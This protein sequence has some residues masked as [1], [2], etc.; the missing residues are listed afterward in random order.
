MAEE[1][2]MRIP[3]GFILFPLKGL[4]KG[5]PTEGQPPLTSPAM[6]N[7][8]PF[9]VF[10][11]RARG[12][13]R[14]GLDKKYEQQVGS[15]TQPISKLLSV[16]TVKET[17]VAVLSGSGTVGDPYRIY[18]INDLQMVGSFLTSYFILMNNIDA[19][20]T[21]TWNSGAGFIPIGNTGTPFT[22]NM[23]GQGYTVFNLTMDNVDSATGTGL[24]GSTS[25]AVV[26]NL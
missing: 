17:D 13:Q 20:V 11:Q 23:D 4:D 26:A 21:S 9:D 16:T 6:D 22:G 7:V 25:G 19:T 15:S 2:P 10:D 3:D 12:G 8:R 24:F 1:R 14:P 18:T 5:G